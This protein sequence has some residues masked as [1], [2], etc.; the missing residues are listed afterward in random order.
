MPSFVLL[1][2][3]VNCLLEHALCQTFEKYI[4]FIIIKR[5]DLLK[6]KQQD[7]L[8]VKIYDYNVYLICNCKTFTLFAFNMHSFIRESSK[9]NYPFVSIRHV[10]F[11]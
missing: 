2:M 3:N 10:Y 5:L 8:G 11:V 6:K 1:L 4:I 9:K 7:D